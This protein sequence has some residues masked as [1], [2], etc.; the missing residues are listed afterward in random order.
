MSQPIFTD[1]LGYE[2]K[3]TLT[4]KRDNYIL[5]S[6]TYKNSG[7]APLFT[8]LG[9]CLTGNYV[10]AQEY[11][12]CKIKLL[13]NKSSQPDPEKA[14][15]V[16]ERSSFIPIAQPP[17]MHDDGD[18]AQ[19][20]VVYSFEIPKPAIAPNQ[21]FNQVALYRDNPN[22]D[23]D[24]SAYYFLTDGAGNFEKNQN[25]TDWSATTVLL[26]EWELTLSNKN[27]VNQEEVD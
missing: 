20:R 14:A 27:I 10:R 17:M 26:L 1:G 6:H 13:F 23:E 24:F 5:K 2:G 25:T 16:E 3:V 12:P 21:N 9:L 7:T 22:N 15:D 8:F 11:Q 19:V 18:A 4:L